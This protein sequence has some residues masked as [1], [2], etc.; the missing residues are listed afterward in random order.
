MMDNL[1]SLEPRAGLGPERGLKDAAAWDSD[2]ELV[3]FMVQELKD[4][5]FDDESAR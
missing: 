1:K 3:R 2:Y 5:I 4:I